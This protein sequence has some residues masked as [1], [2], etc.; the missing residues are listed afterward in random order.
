MKEIKI[1]R[2]TL[3]EKKPYYFRY[4]Y[5]DINKEYIDFIESTEINSLR[6]FRKTIEELKSTKNKTEKEIEFLDWYEKNI[7]LS[8]NPCVINRI[9][10][11]V[12]TSFDGDFQFQRNDKSDFDYS[13]YKS[14]VDSVA[15]KSEIKKI[16]EL[17]KDFVAMNRNQRIKVD[18]NNKEELLQSNDDRYS[19]MKLKLMDIISDDNLLLNTM[20]EL[21]YKSKKISKTFVWSLM[22]NKIIENLLIRSDYT[23]EYPMQAKDGDILYSGMNFK[24]VK[25]NLKEELNDRIN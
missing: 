22:G 15:T 3:T 1:L 4:I 5:K 12:E 8:N 25:K 17:Y 11:K 18:Y 9:A 19:E 7:P 2:N 16:I 20:L 24:M 23:I 14:D 13:I 6:S 10:H 21:S